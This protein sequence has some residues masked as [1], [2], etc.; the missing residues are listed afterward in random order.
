MWLL[1]YAVCIARHAPQLHTVVGEQASGA[2][3]KDSSDAENDV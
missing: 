3:A 1:V 2:K